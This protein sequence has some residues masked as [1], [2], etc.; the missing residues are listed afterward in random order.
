MTSP[1]K[2]TNHHYLPRSYLAFFSE[3]DR[4]A[5]VDR[6]TGVQR[7]GDPTNTAREKNFYTIVDAEGNGRDDLEDAFSELEGRAKTVIANMNCGFRLMPRYNQ[8]DDLAEFIALQALRTA[9]HS[10]ETRGRRST[11]D[12]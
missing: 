1:T 4:I 8:R 2:R 7:I 12:D 5:T 6:V 10:E 11:V 9:R 3:D